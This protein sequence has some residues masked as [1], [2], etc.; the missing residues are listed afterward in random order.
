MEEI[1]H[2]ELFA[3]QV[4]ATCHVVDTS[5]MRVVHGWQIKINA[6]L[7]TNYKQILHLDADNIVAKDPTYLFDCQ[8]FKD[9]AAMFWMDNPVVND[10]DALPSSSGRELASRAND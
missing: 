1:A 2:C 9:N 6:I 10:L 8:E 7:Q 3:R 4:A 5:K